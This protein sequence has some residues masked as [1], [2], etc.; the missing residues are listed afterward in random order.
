M[1]VHE[2]HERRALDTIETGKAISQR[3]LSRELGIALGLTNLLLRKMARKGWV[4]L[5]HVKS[6]RIMYFVTPAGIAE[7][8]R[9]TQEYFSRNVSFYRET[10]DRIQQRFQELSQMWPTDS[11]Q[12][13]EKRIAFYGANEVAEI[14]F[15]CL[16]ETDLKL[17]GVVDSARRGP[18]FGV[19]VYPPS[20]LRGRHLDGTP[21]DRVVVMSFEG[22]A[23]L[24]QPLATLEIPENMIVW[25]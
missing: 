12:P 21:I 16:Q 18:F 23:S 8:T 5:V 11:D 3:S 25:I 10:R 7:K 13:V 22:Q 9:M 15:I 24:Q 20:A 14:G 2:L 6:N 1:T 17:V 19:P 4:R